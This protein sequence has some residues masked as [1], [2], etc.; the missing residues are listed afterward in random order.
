[1]ISPFRVSGGVGG[2]TTAVDPEEG[3]VC[4]LSGVGGRGAFVS[5]RI[6][7]MFYKG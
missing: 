3:G 4:G 2:P 1:M 7:S 5:V 6:W